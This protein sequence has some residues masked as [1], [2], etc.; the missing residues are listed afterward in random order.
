[1]AVV[2]PDEVQET[3]PGIFYCSRSFVAADA[4]MIAFLKEAA[5]RLPQ[6]RARLCAHPDPKASQHDMLIVARRDGY[7]S[8]HRHPAKTESFLV[9]EG[10]CEALLFDADGNVTDIFTMGPASS[11]QPFFY[12]MPAMTYHTMEVRSDYFVYVESA[13]GPFD[14]GQ[15]ENAPWAP[16]PDQVAKGQRYISELI[17]TFG[18][19]S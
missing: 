2:T 5:G 10:E 14:P 1:M 17:R 18:T 7:V 11:G 16:A 19:R 8:P 4:R 3:A 6:R 15:S 9:I 13:K 12:R